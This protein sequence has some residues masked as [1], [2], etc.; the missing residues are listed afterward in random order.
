[1]TKTA[2]A[3]TANTLTPFDQIKDLEISEKKR[4]EQEISAMQK[5]EER[6]KQAIA[7]REQEAEGQLHEEARKYL[8]QYRKTELS[9]VLKK[10]KHDAAK[11]VAELEKDYETKKDEVIKNL[12]KKAT[13]PDFLFP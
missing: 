10:G 2:K 1:M 6:C 11:A 5:E 9:T 8:E 7:S 13:D 12:V 3:K 4:L